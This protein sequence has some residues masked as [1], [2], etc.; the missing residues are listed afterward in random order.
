M[1]KKQK[2]RKIVAQNKRNRLSN[3]HYSS[4]IKTLLKLFLIKM[5]LF[6][7]GNEIFK[8]N[9]NNKNL[10][11][12]TKKYGACAESIGE[13]QKMEIKLES[14]LNEIYSVLDKAISKKVMH[15]NTATKKKSKIGKIFSKAKIFSEKRRRKEEK[16]IIQYKLN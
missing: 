3:K 1:S 7:I 16:K 13:K 15:K 14:L 5:K 12:R 11:I 6:L 2:N 8:S 9:E 10:N 4:T